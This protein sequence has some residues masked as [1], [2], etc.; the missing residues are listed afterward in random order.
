MHEHFELTENH[1]KYRT[2]HS[3]FCFTIHVTP[4][5]GA[6]LT[7]GQDP[8]TKTALPRFLNRTLRPRI[9]IT[10]SHTVIGPGIG[11]ILAQLIWHLCDEGD[12]V[13]MT[14]VHCI[15]LRQQLVAD[16]YLLYVALLR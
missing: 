2:F 5:L 13:L 12:G 11:A 1:L 6:A 3:S 8:S 9:P 14:A 16:I 10:P 4:D 7:L 15:Y